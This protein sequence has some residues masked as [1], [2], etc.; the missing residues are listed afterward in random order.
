MFELWH[1]CEGD[2]DFKGHPMKI[3]YKALL[4]GPYA[5]CIVGMALNAVVNLTNGQ[6]MPVFPPGGDC[7]LIGVH[8]HIHVCMTH[9]SHFKYL[10]DIFLSN[11][12]VSSLGD[13]FQDVGNATMTAMGLAWALLVVRDTFKRGE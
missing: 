5:L 3:P 10:A 11:D 7:T 4:F 8:D 13:L 9:A 2:A 12:A 6:Q 1:G